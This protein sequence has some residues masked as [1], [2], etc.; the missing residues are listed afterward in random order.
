MQTILRI[1]E[2]AGDFRPPLYPQIKNP[3]THSFPNAFTDK[4]IRG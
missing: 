3:D 1:F 4:S 2:W